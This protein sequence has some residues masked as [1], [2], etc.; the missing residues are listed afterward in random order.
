MMLLP[1]SSYE[2]AR[3]ADRHAF[4]FLQMLDN[5]GGAEWSGV[6]TDYDG[7]WAILFDPCIAGAFTEEE[8]ANVI[9]GEGWERI[10]HEN[11]DRPADSSA[12]LLR[13]QA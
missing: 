1:F 9:E 12:D 6:F 2:D 11:P 4:A 8:L 5:A 10:T 3:A 7:Q 13:T